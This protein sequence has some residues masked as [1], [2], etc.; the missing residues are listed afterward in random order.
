M[1]KKVEEQIRDKLN[2]RL[3]LI[4]TGLTLIEDEYHVKNP[5]GA[6]GFI[7]IFAKDSKGNLVI[8]ELKRSDAAARE[9][10]T[11]LSKYIALIRRIKNVKNSEVRLIVIST[12][13]H[14]LLVPFSEFYNATNYQLEGYLLRTD[15]H[16]EPLTVERITPL[17]KIKGRHI[18][19]RHFIRYYKTD[20]DFQRAEESIVAQANELGIN[21]FLIVKFSLNFVDKYYGS[22]RVL[23]WAQQLKTREFYIDQ[24]TDHIDEEELEEFLEGISDMDEDDALDELAD[25]LDDQIEVSCEHCEIGHPEKLVQRLSDNLWTLVS[26]AKYGVFKEDNRL[27]DDLLMMDLKGYTGTSFV[28]YF[29]SSTT[30]NRAKIE[31]I[32]KGI[33]SCLF[34]NDVWRH[35]VKDIINYASNKA[36]CSITIYVFSKD[37]LLETFWLSGTDNPLSWTPIFYIIIDP[38]NDDNAEIFIGK[39]TWNKKEINIEQAIK[40][41]YETFNDYM[42][43]RHLGEQRAKDS[44][45]MNLL[46]FEYQVDQIIVSPSGEEHKRNISVRGKSISESS[47]KSIPFSEFL[48]DRQDIVNKVIKLFS[49]RTTGPGVFTF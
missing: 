8:I 19:R 25:R 13:W 30:E 15:N 18:C 48:H 43:Y 3:D 49:D 29:A 36:E 1:K 42:L 12:E 41:V 27:T 11:E 22:T 26:I 17:P 37:D 31:E 46:G 39:V 23:Y 40:D 35:K 44:E 2:K 4:E 21:D 28:Y 33:D 9:A 45:L 6:G 10:I 20:I 34:H 24:L 5:N 47:T 7:D 32:S 16:Y 14:E 38:K